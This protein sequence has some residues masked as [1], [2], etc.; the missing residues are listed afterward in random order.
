MGVRAGGGASEIG[1]GYG[2]DVLR[3]GLTGGIGSGKST[4]ARELKRLGAFVLDADALAREVVAPG[5]P[6]LAAVVEEFGDEVLLPDGSLDRARL[7]GIVFA[8]AEA[9]RRLGEIT[10][11]LVAAESVRHTLAAPREVIVVHDVPLIVENGLAGDY[12]VV[13]VVGAREDVRLGRVVAERGLRPE[14][15]LARIRAQADD[16]A[17]RAVADVWLDNNGTVEELLAAV[18]R[19]WRERLVPLNEAMLARGTAP[20]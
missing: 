19:L 18:R 2:R 17:R 15:A 10:H 16:A 4:A 8:D 14:D 6:G 3:V 1:E 5:T 13:V 7:A 12:D 11:P 20:K 9:L